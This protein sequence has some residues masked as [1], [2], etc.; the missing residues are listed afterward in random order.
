MSLRDKAAIAGVGLT[1]FYRRGQ[2]GARSRLQLDLEAILVACEDAGIAPGEIDGFSTYLEDTTTIALARA[3]GIPELRF[4][5]IVYGGGGGGSCAAVGNAVMAIDAGLAE[6]VVV[7]QGLKQIEGQRRGGSGRTS[8]PTP[9]GGAPFGLL[10]PA[11]NFAL[12]LR[13]HMEL[14]GTTYEHLGH[15]AITEREHALRNPRALMREPLTM[16]DYLAA[17][18]IAD[19]LR[20]FDCTQENDAAGALVV[21]S[22]ER[23]RDLQQRP[24]YV[25]GVAQGGAS[26]WGTFLG[27]HT[28]PDELYATAGHAPMARNLYAMAGVGPEDVDVAELYDHFSGMVLLQLEDYGL[29]PRGESGPFVAGGGIKWAGGKVPVNTHGGHLSEVFIVGMGH[30]VEAVRQIRGTSTSQVEGAEV[31][32]VTGGPSPVPSS[33][34]ILH[35]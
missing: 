6:V 22:A 24:A 29:A 17:R 16:D 5:N 18:M 31:V 21:V 11:Q 9:Y 7:Y 34:M 14:Y 25:M 30:M 8:P 19:P 26:R 23:A 13:R 4:S 33:S 35:A 32:L 20:L 27:E 28:M 15:V 1:D 12:I 2:S 3:L 10:S